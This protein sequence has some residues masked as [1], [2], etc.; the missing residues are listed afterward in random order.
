MISR[1]YAIPVVSAVSVC[2]GKLC[3]YERIMMA[4]GRFTIKVVCAMSTESVCV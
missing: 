4:T 1:I 3:E 2:V